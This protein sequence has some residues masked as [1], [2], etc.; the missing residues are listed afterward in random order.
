MKKRGDKDIQELDV[1]S[2][3]GRAFYCCLRKPEGDGPF[4]A[5]IFIHGGL[6]DDP[7]YT[8]AMLEW[9]A[10]EL[11]LQESFVV[12]SSDYR[13]DLTGKDIGDVAAAFKYVAGQPF[14]DGQKIAYFGDSHGAFLAIMAATQT[15]PFALIH[16]W[17][18]ADMAD[19]YR[20]IKNIPVSYYQKV[21][22]D[23]EKS[24]GGTPDQAPKGYRLLSPT[25]HVTHIKCPVL[26]LHGEE[27]KEV[28]VS[29][30]HQLADAIEKAG[31]TQEIKVFNNAGHGLRSPE[32]RRVM[33][34]L[35]L[36]FLNRYL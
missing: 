35:V 34:P 1:T 33:D 11:L 5:V 17:G 9:S 13:V 18:V 8:R 28:P 15:D 26:I 19:W 21:T 12:F 31:G 22:G 27:D 23:F 6:G 30:A 29:H 3:D 14:V 36:E 4:P 10:A 7:K 2:A 20:H 25:T 16:G 32:V 24:L